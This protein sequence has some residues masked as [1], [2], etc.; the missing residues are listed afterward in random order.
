MYWGI[1][2][3][4]VFVFVFGVIGVCLAVFT[5]ALQVAAGFA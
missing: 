3:V 2:E 4:F 1:D 5:Q